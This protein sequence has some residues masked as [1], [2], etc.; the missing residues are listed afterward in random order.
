MIPLLLSY[1]RLHK[2][3]DILNTMKMATSHKRYTGFAVIII[4][5]L[6]T[7]GYL[8]WRANHMTA[9]E[10]VSQITTT[11]PATNPPGDE[12]LF[13]AVNAKQTDKIATLVK[14]GAKLNEQDS[15]GR[16]AA[17]IATYNDDYATAKVLIE[18]GADVNIR[19]SIFNNPFLYAGAEGYLDILKL[20]VEHGADPTLLNRY[21]GTALIPAGE[22][23]HVEVINYLLENTKVDINHV[24]TPGWTALLEAIVLNN[25]G[26]RQQQAVQLLVDH[27]ADVNIADKNGVT[28]LQHARTKGFTA[29]ARILRDAG[30]H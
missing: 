14:Q 20:T 5:I 11:P 16:T 28:P 1:R 4:V 27:G 13:T 15:Q 8:I 19:D 21:G 10:K 24:N 3:I 30:G 23:G 12:E 25:G 18:A 29:I 7:S 17:M 6:L 22:H 2:Q 9:S 26:P